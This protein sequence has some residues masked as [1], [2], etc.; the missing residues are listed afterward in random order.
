MAFLTWLPAAAKVAGID[1]YVMPGALTRSTWR[2]G[3]TT[4]GVVWHH[5][6]TGK[7]W[8]D[9]HVAFL[10]RDGRPDLKGPL[11]QFGIE[12]DGTAVM[13]AAGR[14]NHNGYGRWG[15]DSVG[16]EFYNDG[17]GELLTPAQTETGLKLTTLICKYE[18]L[19]STKVEAHREQDPS[20]KIDLL[21]FVLSMS[22]IRASV[23]RRLAGTVPPSPNFA[24]ESSVTLVYLLEQ[25]RY[26]VVTPWGQKNITKE[27]GY[28]IDS[29]NEGVQAWKLTNAEWEAIRHPA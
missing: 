22:A 7:N 9:G 15:N 1:L 14:C 3:F 13:V 28:V 16:L 10:L 2:S 23:G 29:R 8:Q 12:R 5:T 11:A 20:R 25:E 21:P 18:G 27:Q 6:A 17:K 4:R 19:T 26:I 24:K